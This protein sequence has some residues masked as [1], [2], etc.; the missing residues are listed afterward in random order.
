[1]FQSD[2]IQLTRNSASVFA[3]EI[4]QNVFAKDPNDKS[5]WERFRRG[6]LQYGGSRNEREV[7]EEFLG[8]EPT[9]EA[10]IRAL[11]LD[12]VLGL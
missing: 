11:D 6:I 7:L 8:R 4:F 5:A 2:N 3:E 12:R 9:P 1:M 10:L